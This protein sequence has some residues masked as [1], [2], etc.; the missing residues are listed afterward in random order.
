MNL[1]WKGWVVLDGEGV[2][3]RFATEIDP[4]DVLRMASHGWRVIPADLKSAETPTE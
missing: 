2:L 4:A 1:H 3:I